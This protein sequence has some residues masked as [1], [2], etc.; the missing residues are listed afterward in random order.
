MNTQNNRNQDVF[1]IDDMKS[2]NGGNAAGLAL[3]AVFLIVA[4]LVFA[5]WSSSGF[6]HTKAVS[7]NQAS[8]GAMKST[9]ELDDTAMK[10]AIKAS[11]QQ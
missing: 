7:N 10:T 3:G 5:V 2:T 9:P 8:S 11:P 1:E 6:E 4:M